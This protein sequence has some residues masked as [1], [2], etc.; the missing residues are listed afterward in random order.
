MAGIVKMPKTSALF[1]PS[2]FKIGC[3][4]V[5]L[6]V[7][8]FHSFNNSKPVLLQSL[9]NRLTDA[10]F[11]LRGPSA[12]TG[13]VV[14]VDI[15]NKSL[16]KL[17]QWPWSRKTVATLIEQIGTRQPKAIII[18]I[19]FAEADRTSPRN[20]IP[21]LIPHLS[22]ESATEL[23]ALQDKESFNYDLTLGTSLSKLPTV[24]GYALSLETTEQAAPDRPFPTA[25]LHFNPAHISLNAINFIQGK[26]GILNTQDV[27]QAETEGFFNV[28]PDQSGTI[29]KAPLFM[30]YDGIPYP[31][32]ALEGYRLGTGNHDI[33]I[34]LGRK[35]HRSKYP[36]INIMVNNNT[37]ATDE[38]GQL[39]INFRGPNRTF[40]TVSAV[41]VL[42]GLETTVLNN[43]Y[44]LIGTSAEGLYDLRTTPFS[45]II[46]G[47]EI[48]A[49]ILDN[50][51]ASDAMVHDTYT[52][53]A[54][55]YA[56][57]ILGGLSLAAILAYS[58]PLAGGLG[59]IFCIL[60]TFVTCYHVLFLN[61]RII[62]ITY[63]LL[64]ITLIFLSV[65]LFNYIF[66]GRRKRQMSNAFKRY[67]S[68][69][70]VK[71][72]MQNPEAL[73]LSGKT[74]VLTVFF[75]DIKDFT[76]ISETL[77][78][79]QLSTLMNEYLTA[80]SGIILEYE[81][82]VDKFIGD[83]I[84]AIWGAPL[85]VQDQE[86]QAVSAALL[87]IE[88][89]NRLRPE[90]LKQGFPEISIRIGIN[91]GE[92]RVGNFGSQTRFDYTVIGDNVNLAARL[93][94]LSKNYGTDILISQATKLAVEAHFFCRYIDTVRVKGKAIPV[95]IYSPMRFA[96]AELHKDEFGL[97]NRAIDQY[98][99]RQFR[100]A[101]DTLQHLNTEFDDTL[102]QTYMNR[103]AFFLE[104]PPNLEWNGVFTY[105]SK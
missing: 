100:K 12:T 60:A 8:T 64:T 51:I 93:E 32:L 52:E 72:V 90:W 37:I 105:T 69:K 53:I 87:S 22:Q 101:H 31:S 71:Q 18:D 78:P 50:L 54:L 94:G 84:M 26:G 4:L 23:Q 66:E 67:V 55:T 28:F 102:Y 89:L 21:Q 92:M 46:P 45:T 43:R 15:D 39:A 77:S 76:T 85:A 41:D 30:L 61:N 99:T 65:T 68:P 17:G 35:Q 38:T 19:V 7:F 95:R 83:A 33:R 34:N 81:G 44:V 9:D 70:V 59:G 40:T 57:I 104:N 20:L 73:S 5:C 29:R 13:E 98:L 27:A 80:M 36:I 58:T 56:I 86:L 91:S 48:Q 63:P 75:S 97:F 47:V 96:H 42:R 1:S 11:Q 25:N 103:C 62:G 49:N 10:M 82:T 6:A 16:A 24:L 3:L 74:S 2:P 79:E 14:I 88:T